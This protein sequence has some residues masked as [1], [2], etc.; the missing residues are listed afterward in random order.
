MGRIFSRCPTNLAFFVDLG[1][2][3]P[4][5]TFCIFIIVAIFSISNTKS[6]ANTGA[7]PRCLDYLSFSGR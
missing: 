4:A 3:G 6:F 2:V 5:P 1:S 7:F